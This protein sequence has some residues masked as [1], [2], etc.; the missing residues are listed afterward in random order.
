MVKYKVRK[1]LKRFT[2]IKGDLPMLVNPDL[3]YDEKISTALDSLDMV[4]DDEIVYQGL[5]SS[6]AKINWKDLITGALIGGLALM[7]VGYVLGTMGLF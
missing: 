4:L 7:I 2:V 5:K 1:N 3:V 6:D